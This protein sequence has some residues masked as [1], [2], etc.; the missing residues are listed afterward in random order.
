[1]NR[2]G[3]CAATEE[4]ADILRNATS[5]LEEAATRPSTTQL[6]Q[7]DVLTMRGFQKLAKYVLTKTSETDKAAQ[8]LLHRAELCFDAALK[9]KRS[10]RA[11]MGKAC[12]KASR[13]DWHAALECFRAV[14]QRASPPVPE[15]GE[16]LTALKEIRFGLATC[17]AG[18]G[19]HKKAKEAL[20][21]VLAADKYD[22]EALCALAHLEA[23]ECDEGKLR[24]TTYMQ[25]AM[26]AAPSNPAVLLGAANDLFEHGLEA[27]LEGNSVPQYWTLAEQL[28]QKAVTDSNSP[29]TAAEAAYH[30]GRLAQVTKSYRRAAELYKE[31]LRTKPDHLAAAFQCAQ[32]LIHERSYSSAITVLEAAPTALQTRPQVTKLLATA[33][34]ALGQCHPKAQQ[35]CD[36]LV[37]LVP[38]DVEAWALRAQVY[39]TID[40]QETWNCYRAMSECMQKNPEARLTP[41]MWMNVSTFRHAQGLWKEA[42]EA[43]DKGLE[44]LHEAQTQTSTTTQRSKDLRNAEIDMRFNRAHALAS[45]G[46]ETQLREA[47]EEYSKGK[48]LDTDDRKHKYVRL[49][50]AHC[51]F[52][53]QE[54]AK[55][56]EEIT[57]A[58]VLHP[59]DMRFRD[60][61]TAI[62]AAKLKLSE[63]EK[64][65]GEMQPQPKKPPKRTRLRKKT[66][67]KR[68]RLRKKTPPPM[69]TTGQHQKDQKDNKRRK[70]G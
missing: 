21:G 45:S 9:L 31:C 35:H 20:K 43:F 47:I 5:I 22:V 52:Q 58:L 15:A 8:D 41:Q 27:F 10:P 59:D 39:C 60:F 32:C 38:E 13:R 3:A 23:K 61:Q 56:E 63:L 67:P 57:A 50:K 44:L 33:Y 14:L 4:V 51:Y 62:V 29:Q 68:Y 18:L 7:A 28:L 46:E 26:K 17:F 64:Q 65:Q 1:M 48:D 49:C 70:I 37:A 11:L 36:T 69:G 19:R 30:K 53:L 66:P 34:A 12:V 40:E 24:S 25:H 16:Q 55:A 6:S 2:P 42:R 54:L